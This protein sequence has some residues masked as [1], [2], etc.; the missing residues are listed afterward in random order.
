MS[1]ESV[2][3]ILDTAKKIIYGD[4][5]KTYG[6]P[7]KNLECIATMWEAYL[8]SRG[9]LDREGGGI[10]AQ[11]VAIM[12]TLLKCSRLAND[13]SHIDSLVDGAGYLALV[14]R[15]GEPHA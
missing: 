1:E 4:R 12:M 6:H 9:I 3:T 11:D 10:M 14:E 15:C 13:P 5:E 7:A 2:T 8:Y